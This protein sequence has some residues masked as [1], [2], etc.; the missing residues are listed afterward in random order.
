[1]TKKKSVLTIADTIQYYDNDSMYLAG[2]IMQVLIN[3]KKEGRNEKVIERMK[4]DFLAALED[5]IVDFGKNLDE[6]DVE[7][8]L[9]GIYVQ[10]ENGELVP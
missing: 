3:A 4:D 7:V 1:M 9:K 5:I 8:K 2:Q 6:Y 10:I